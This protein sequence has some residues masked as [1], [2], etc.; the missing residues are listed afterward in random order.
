MPKYK[1]LDKNFVFA[2]EGF[3]GDSGGIFGQLTKS[4]NINPAEVKKIED[5]EY[6]LKN[7]YDDVCGKYRALEDAINRREEEI[8]AQTKKINTLTDTKKKVLIES[9]DLKKENDELRDKIMELEKQI[10]ITK[11]SEYS[12]QERIIF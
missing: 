10:I 12:T 5:E 2:S 3:I 9:K 11:D 4:F 6:V 8:K 1:D 7:D